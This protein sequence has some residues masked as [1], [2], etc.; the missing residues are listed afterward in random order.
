MFALNGT[1]CSNPKGNERKVISGHSY[2]VHIVF[3][4][5][6]GQCPYCG[7]KLDI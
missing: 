6:T 3:I 7:E 5:T 4:E 1:H 2:S